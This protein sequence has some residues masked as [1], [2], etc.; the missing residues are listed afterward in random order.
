MTAQAFS[1]IFAPTQLSVEALPQGESLFSSRMGPSFIGSRMTS[2]FNFSRR[3]LKLLCGVALGLSPLMPIRRALA[4]SEVAP[5]IAGVDIFTGQKIEVKPK[6]QGEVILFMSSVCPCSN[7]HL[8]VIKKLAQDYPDYQFVV[9]HSNTDEDVAQ[10][11]HY[12]EE[13]KL[14]FPVIQDSDSK[15]ANVL[16]AMKTPHSFIVNALGQIVYRGGVTSSASAAP[17][18]TQYLRDALE[19]LKQGHPVKTTNGR[20]LGC[21]IRR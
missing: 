1:V 13:A 9:I 2:N 4:A 8:P 14:A 5:L 7:S 12:F 15:F 20:T 3:F 10:A 18:D 16:K 19:D 11:K 17:Q 21:A 6:S